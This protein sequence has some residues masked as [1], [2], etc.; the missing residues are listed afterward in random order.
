MGL[1]GGE[2]E[3]RCK[4]RTKH[5]DEN[6]LAGLFNDCAFD[7]ASIDTTAVASAHL[8][9]ALLHKT[10]DGPVFRFDHDQMFIRKRANLNGARYPYE[11]AVC[12][13]HWSVRLGREW[14]AMC[15]G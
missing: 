10:P 1:H 2:S 11:F 14:A 4:E 9:I 3:C 8:K 15:L 12:K 5:P 6:R 7:V 13:G